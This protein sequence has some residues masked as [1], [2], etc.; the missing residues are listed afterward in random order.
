MIADEDQE[1]KD[2]A[3]AGRRAASPRGTCFLGADVVSG[4]VQ[5]KLR[6]PASLSDPRFLGGNTNDLRQSH[7][8]KTSKFPLSRRLIGENCHGANRAP[9]EAD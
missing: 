4:D 7:A 3:G 6:Q 1:R 9:G 5:V 2:I 8:R